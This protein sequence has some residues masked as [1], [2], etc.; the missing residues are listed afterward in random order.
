MKTIVLTGGGTAGHIMPNLALLPLIKKNFSKIYYLGS[1]DSMEEKIIKEQTD[2]EFIPI[3]AVKLVRKFTFKNFLIPFKLIN[4]ILQTKKI[5]KKIKPDAIFCKGGFVSVPVAIAGK[6]CKIPVI[7]HESDLSMG[8]ANKIILRYASTMCTTFEDT[9]K[10]SN[11]CICTGSP[12]RDQIFNGNKH[13]VLKNFTNY[14]PHLPFVLFFGG[15]LGSVKINKIVEDNIDK[16]LNNYNII[17]ILGKKNSNNINKKG[18]FKQ[19]FVSNIEDYF[20]LADIVVCRGGANSLFE[21]LALNKPMLIIPLSKAESRGDQIENAEYFKRHKFAEVLR[22]EN[23]TPSAL[24]SKLDYIQRNNEQIIANMQK[25]NLA[26][27][28]QKI[29]DIIKEHCNFT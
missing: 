4:G 21:L 15:S 6:K 24:L 11:R 29:V 9:A 22:E 18:Y 5:L 13:N 7:S 27:S 23:L 8:L 17:H 19:N 25:N 10:T 1:K 2:I 20:A 12:I 16:L 28:N 14:N 3:P 26:N